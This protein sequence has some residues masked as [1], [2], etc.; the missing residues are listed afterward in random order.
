MKYHTYSMY[1][2]PWRVPIRQISILN[3]DIKP[4]WA[5]IYCMMYAC[6]SVIS[7]SSFAFQYSR[8]NSIV[9]PTSVT[10]IDRVKIYVIIVFS[11]FCSFHKWFFNLYDYFFPESLL[12]LLWSAGGV[13]ADLPYIHFRRA[14]LPSKLVAF[15]R[16]PHVRNQ[17]W[18][19]IPS[20]I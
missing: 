17:P 1:T 10:S 14:S 5:S 6:R 13:F 20:Y 2:K 18:E 9:I 4:W 7:I 19:V 15:Y 16:N 12:L 8:L 3:G 11:V